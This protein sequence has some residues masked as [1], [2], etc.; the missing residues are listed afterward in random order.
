MGNFL[1]FSKDNRIP[2]SEPFDPIEVFAD[3]ATIAEWNN[4]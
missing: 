3:A 2:I 1:K 4:N